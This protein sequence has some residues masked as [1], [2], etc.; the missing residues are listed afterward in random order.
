MKNKDILAIVLLL[1]DFGLT[2]KLAFKTGSLLQITYLICGCVWCCNSQRIFVVIKLVL[3]ASIKHSGIEYIF[4]LYLLRWV[5]RISFFVSEYFIQQ[6]ILF[7]NKRVYHRVSILSSRKPLFTYW[8]IKLSI[9]IKSYQYLNLN[10]NLST[11]LYIFYLTS[12]LGYLFFYLSIYFLPIYLCC[13]SFYFF[14]KYVNF[15]IYLTIHQ[16][17]ILCIVISIH[18]SNYLSTYMYI[19]LSVLSIYLEWKGYSWRF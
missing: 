16:S 15:N 12:Y 14:P 6:E 7:Q 4:K 17:L 3:D 13:I 2:L 10:S 9:M 11:Y 5:W 18:L 8:L 1:F 19:N